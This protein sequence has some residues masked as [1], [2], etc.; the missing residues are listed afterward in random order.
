MRNYPPS[1]R[2]RAARIPIQA[3]IRLVPAL[4]H[5]SCVISPLR[6]A[7]VASGFPA[8]Q[9]CTPPPA[10]ARLTEVLYTLWDFEPNRCRRSLQPYA[11]HGADG[12]HHSEA[13]TT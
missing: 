4:P 1:T 5:A 13:R 10:F 7:S 8:A 2:L 3:I 9:R 6:A 11:S 12:A